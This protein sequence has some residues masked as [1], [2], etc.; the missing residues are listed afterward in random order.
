VNSVD[1]RLRH[2]FGINH[3]G[4]APELERYLLTQ[5]FSEQS[6]FCYSEQDI[7]EQVRKIEYWYSLGEFDCDKDTFSS[8]YAHYCA[9]EDELLEGEVPF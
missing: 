2:F 6:D 1:K 9:F 3:R 5:Y 7:T 8:A 4:F